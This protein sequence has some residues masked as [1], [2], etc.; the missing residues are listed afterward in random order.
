MIVESVLS[1]YPARVAV[2]IINHSQNRL[3]ASAIQT[4]SETQVIQEVIL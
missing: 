4:T 1:G 3:F 2:R